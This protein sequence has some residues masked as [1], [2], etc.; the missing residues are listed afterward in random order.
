MMNIWPFSRKHKK[1]DYELQVEQGNK[2]AD[3]RRRWAFLD[4]KEV[5]YLLG[6]RERRAVYEWTE[7]LI[8]EF[9]PLDYSAHPGFRDDFFHLSHKLQAIDHP[10]LIK[11]VDFGEKNGRLYRAWERR[12]FYP[13]AF[14]HDRTASQEAEAFLPLL[15]TLELLGKEIAPN[16]AR[17]PLN[18]F[19]TDAHGHFLARPPQTLKKWRTFFDAADREC[20][21]PLVFHQHAEENPEQD[22]DLSYQFALGTLIWLKIS[23]AFPYSKPP[24]A[25]FNGL[26]VER[27]NQDF[28]PNLGPVLYRLTNLDMKARYPTL[29]EALAAIQTALKA[30]SEELGTGAVEPCQSVPII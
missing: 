4:Q 20:N 14:R 10:G 23:K 29:Q 27:Q 1:S 9:V 17:F 12:T 7:K 24:M 13:V 8:F 30:Y 21:S 28:G 2:E 15:Q 6:R 3:E 11:L 16:L 18:S 19:S 26:K 25:R 22:P 5:R